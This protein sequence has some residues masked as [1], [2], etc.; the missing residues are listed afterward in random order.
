MNTQA[1]PLAGLGILV[2]RPAH[3]AQH[4]AERIRAAGGE[5]ILFPVLEIVDVADLAPLN[6]LIDHLDQFD[7]AIFISPNAVAKAMNL[8]L[9]RRTLPASLA[10]AAV[11]QGS[12]RALKERGVHAVIAPTGRFDSEALL[13]LAPLKAVQG[14][15]VVIFRG[16]GGREH[17]A[18]VLASRGARVEYAECYRRARPQGESARLLHLWARGALHAITVTSSESLHN[19]F[20]L[21]GKLGQQWLRATPLFVP[22]ERIAQA[23]RTLGLSHVILTPPGDEGL[24]AGL[25]AWRQGQSAR[26]SQ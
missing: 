24:V 17:L 9:A 20:E 25:I 12:A 11:G 5:P 4:L 19:L 26:I 16:E 21:V 2:T 1:G 23:A 15:R 6:A 22:H 18:E 8:I 7:L 10:I 3:Q 14:K 13:E